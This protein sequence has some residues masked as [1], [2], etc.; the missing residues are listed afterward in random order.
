MKVMVSG[1]KGF[2]GRYFYDEMISAG[3]EVIGLN[4]DLVDVDNVEKQI[5]EAQPE[6]FVH[7]AA[8]ALVSHHN[9]KQMYD[10]N[11]WGA[12]NVLAALHKSG[13][14]LRVVVLASSANIYGNTS[15]AIN[16][17]APPAPVND[18]AVTKLSMEYM[19]KT[20]LDKLPIIIARPFNYTGVGQSASFLIPKI[21]DHFSRKASVIELGNIDVARD[22]GDVR[23]VALAY[24]LILEKGVV[25]ETYNIATGVPS[26]LSD[27]LDICSTITGHQIKVQINPEFV[28]KN[29]IKV[30]VGDSS[31]LAAMAGFY[32]RYDLQQTLQWML[33]K[34]D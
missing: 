17:L 18:Y 27:V 11:V 26:S 34:I 3:H 24:R 20:W 6:A 4:A 33:K 2:T 16:E 14:P 28:R 29:E 1:L 25:G 5:I 31:K 21:V 23:D 7:F 32:R 15:G 19:A 9:I 13:A 22:F 12:R 8:I 10:V 30:L